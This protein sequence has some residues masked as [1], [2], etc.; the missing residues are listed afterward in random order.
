M[1]LRS[2]VFA[3]AGLGALL[4]AGA[5]VAADPL[6]RADAVRLA[7]ES[8]PDVK[9]AEENLAKLHGFVTEARA[10]ALPEIKVLGQWARFRDPSLLNRP[11]F[12]NFPPESKRHK[13]ERESTRS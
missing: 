2:K 6:S 4:G 13:A 11:S 1:N 3:A 10:D 9:K 5:P 12:D 8:N 7:L